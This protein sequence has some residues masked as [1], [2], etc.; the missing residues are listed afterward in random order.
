MLEVFH[1]IN[2]PD[3]NIQNESLPP[4]KIKCP[5]GGKYWEMGARHRLARINRRRQVQL[6]QFRNGGGLVAWQACRAAARNYS[7]KKNAILWSGKPLG[8]ADLDIHVV[9]HPIDINNAK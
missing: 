3:L 2:T 4:P 6:F 7:G 9:A 8:I 1:N 5:A